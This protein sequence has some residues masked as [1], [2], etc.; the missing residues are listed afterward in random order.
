[1]K[2]VKLKTDK[3]DARIIV[4]YGVEQSPKSHRPLTKTQKELKS[5]RTIREHLIRQRTMTRNLLHSH[6]LLPNVTRESLSAIKT[7]LKSLNTQ[8]QKLD[9][10]I[11]VII[12]EHYKDTY[13]QMLSIKGV[14]TK[15]ATGTIAYLGDLNN[16]AHHKQIASYIG[17]TPDIRQ[18]GK[19]LNNSIGI[20]KQG[21]ANLRTLFY[22]AVLSAA[23]TNSACKQLYNRLLLNGKQKKSDLIAVANKLIKQLFAIV[24]F[25]NIKEFFNKSII[26]VN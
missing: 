9:V 10:K 20:T 7:T 5:L 16:F 14:G 17:I 2:R 15:T 11:E 6:N 25:N 21:N 1:M 19:S 4:Q 24:K 13:V 18:S 22:M 23:R 26:C 8:T 3:A 12:K